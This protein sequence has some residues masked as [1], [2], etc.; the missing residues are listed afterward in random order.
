MGQG[1]KKVWRAI[2]MAVNQ[3]AAEETMARLTF[4]VASFGL[5]PNKPLILVELIYR[6][7]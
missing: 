7:R 3:T 5:Q 4:V 1:A 2:D 6:K